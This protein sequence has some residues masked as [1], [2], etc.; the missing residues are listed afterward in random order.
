[1]S[2]SNSLSTLSNLLF[3]QSCSW[4]FFVKKDKKKRRILK[5][6]YRI[7]KKQKSWRSHNYIKLS[8][9]NDDD[10]LI[11][12]LKY[13]CLKC[14][15]WWEINNP[16]SRLELIAQWAFCSFLFWHR[17]NA[18]FLFVIVFFTILSWPRWPIDLKPLQ[19]C[20]FMYV[21]DHIKCL[22]C[23]QLFC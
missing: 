14:H 19:V 2:H 23:Q 10:S 21:M 13:F 5:E 8:R 6:R 22:H 3:G 11:H 15:I 4:I 17:C 9:S 1:M 18:K 20:Q 16:T 7:G 12:P